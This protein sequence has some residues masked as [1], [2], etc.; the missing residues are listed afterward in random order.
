MNNFK[1]MLQY[2][3]KRSGLSQFGLAKRLG[4]SP[5]S[6]SMYENG[7]RE[8]NF[9]TLELIADF[10][11]VDMNF[12]LGEKDKRELSYIKQSIE[13]LDIGNR[14]KY[15]RECLGLTIDD[16]AKDLKMPKSTILRY[17]KGQIP[18]KLSDLEK[19]AKILQTTPAYLINWE[20]EPQPTPT[21]EVASVPT[22]ESKYKEI[23]DTLDTMNDEGVEEVANYAKYTATKPQYKK[24]CESEVVLTK[25][26]A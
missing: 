22:A 3:R 23:T 20:D 24:L 19:L 21:A 25:E 6:I 14:I 16:I 4:I 15:R 8:P 26:E 10:F 9:E 18:P 17:E 11:N 7:K 1:T 12:L 2:L 5:S 13:T